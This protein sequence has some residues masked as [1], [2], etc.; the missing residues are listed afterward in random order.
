[1]SAGTRPA[2]SSSVRGGRVRQRVGVG[3]A[4]FGWLGQAHSRSGAG[5]AIGFEDLVVIED[6][7]FCRAVAEERPFEP[8]FEQAL[9][10][11]SVQDA[12]LRSVDG[13]RWEDVVPLL[14]GEPA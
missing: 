5:N 7:E 13:G 3:V 14:G 11:A 2:V 8:G 12:L 4:G 6:H 1:M 9:A 10:W